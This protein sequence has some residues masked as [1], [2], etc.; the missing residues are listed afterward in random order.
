MAD[1]I[2]V[3][4]TPIQRNTLD[5]ATELTQLYFSRV[6]FESIE[7]IQETFLKFYTVAYHANRAKVDFDKYMPE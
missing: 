2:R 5:V 1:D 7:E 4:P 3:N 6:A